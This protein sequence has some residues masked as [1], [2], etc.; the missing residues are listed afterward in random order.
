MFEATVGA[1]TAK[2]SVFAFVSLFAKVQSAGVLV[3]VFAKNC[4]GIECP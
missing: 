3:S 2:G 4:T 1:V